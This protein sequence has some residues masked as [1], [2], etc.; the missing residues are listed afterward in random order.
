MAENKAPNKSTAGTPAAQ[1]TVTFL[2]AANGKASGK[3]QSMQ[4][5]PVKPMKDEAGNV[6]HVPMANVPG[7]GP[8]LIMYLR[9]E[10]FRSNAGIDVEKTALFEVTV[11]PI[12]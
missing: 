5:V 1:K 3:G 9:N 7:G 12:E 4:F 2:V 6:L 10:Y 11:K 8:T